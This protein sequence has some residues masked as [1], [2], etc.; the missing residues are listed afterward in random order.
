MN[1]RPSRVLDDKWD[2]C[3]VQ[4]A[5]LDYMPGALVAIVGVGAQCDGPL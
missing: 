4:F 5:S 1:L 2:N 3:K